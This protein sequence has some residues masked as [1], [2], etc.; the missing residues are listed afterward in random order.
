MAKSRREQPLREAPSSVIA[1]SPD[2]SG[3][4]GNLTGFAEGKRTVPGPGRK[5]LLLSLR[6]AQRRSNLKTG[7]LI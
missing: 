3:R 6:V 2:D 5:H 7:S 1:R 4:R